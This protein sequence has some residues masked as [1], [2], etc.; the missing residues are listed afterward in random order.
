MTAI[1]Y[2]SVLFKFSLFLLRRLRKTLFLLIETK[3]TELRVPYYYYLFIEKRKLTNLF[4]DL[5]SCNNTW[6]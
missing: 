2:L 1:L 4:E 3:W 6:C 5:I